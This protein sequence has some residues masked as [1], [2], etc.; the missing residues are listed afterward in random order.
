MQ[1]ND[2]IIKRIC[3]Q[4]QET[5]SQID[6]WETRTHSDNKDNNEKNVDRQI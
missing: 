5:E 3:H 1:I 4:R 2:A 6:K